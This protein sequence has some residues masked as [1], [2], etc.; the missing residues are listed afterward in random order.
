MAAD[1]SSSPATPTPTPPGLPAPPAARPTGRWCSR[2]ARRGRPP[3]RSTATAPRV[4]RRPEIV[5]QVPVRVLPRAAGW[6]STWCSTA[7]RQHRSQFVFT[8]LPAAVRGSS[9]RP[10]APPARPGPASAC[11]PRGPPGTSNSRSPSTPGS[12]TRTASPTSRP[13][14]PR[15]PC[16]PATTAC[17]S[18]AE[19][20]RRGRGAQGADRPGQPPDRRELTYQLADL[21]RLPR[22]AVVVE[23]RYARIFKLEHVRPGLRRRAAGHHPG[24][25][26]DRPDLLRRDPAAGRG[27]DVPLPRRRP[28]V[29]ASR[30]GRP[31]LALTR[32]RASRVGTNF[33]RSAPLDR[34]L[35]KF[36]A[37]HPSEIANFRPSTASGSSKTSSGSDPSS[38]GP[39]PACAAT[40]PSACSPPSS[41]R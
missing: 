10:R 37:D 7:A 2:P 24:P 20:A 31:L 17:T 18:T 38:T 8:T 16:P 41:R 4:A 36:P 6:P 3:P 19:L 25:L 27:V 9:G 13:P 15:G 1:L 33:G 23:D 12:A 34:F 32:V 40:S 29:R 26:P 30:T 11:R 35:P 22:A 39:S 5:E 28:R 14:P 21:A